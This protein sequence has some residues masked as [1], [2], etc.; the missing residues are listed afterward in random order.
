[1]VLFSRRFWN[2]VISLDRRVAAAVA[3]CDS[4]A[5]RFKVSGVA[6]TQDSRAEFHLEFCESLAELRAALNELRQFQ[7][8]HLGI[9]R[10]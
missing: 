2:S 9:P 7:E 3:N 1:M 6:L 8:R 4:A 5:Q 10:E